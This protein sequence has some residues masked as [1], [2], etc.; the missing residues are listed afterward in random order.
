MDRK[1]TAADATSLDTWQRGYCSNLGDVK[2]FASTPTRGTCV[3]L[4]MQS[5]QCNYVQF[6]SAD[7]DCGLASRCQLPLRAMQHEQYERHY[8]IDARA[9]SPLCTAA[10]ASSVEAVRLAREDA[11]SAGRASGQHA[12]WWESRGWPAPLPPSQAE[13]SVGVWLRDSQPTACA[14]QHKDLG[15]R[16]AGGMVPWHVAPNQ[17]E[18]CDTA[19]F[20]LFTFA[21][22]EARDW[23]HAVRACLRR[24]AVCARCRHISVAPAHGVCTWH[25]ACAAPQR[26][27]LPTG[28]IEPTPCGFR[29]GPVE[30]A[31]RPDGGGGSSENGGEGGG[32][33]GGGG[34]AVVPGGVALV[35]FG[36]HGGE[37]DSVE[38]RPQNMGAAQAQASAPLIERSH[39]RWVANLVNANGGVAFDVFIHSWSPEAAPYLERAWGGML[40][41][42]QHEPTRYADSTSQL[43]GFQCG[44]AAINCARTASQL[45]GVYKALLL[46]REHELAT[47]RVYAAAV[48]ARHDVSLLAPVEL[49]RSLWPTAP[50]TDD[51][52][53]GGGGVATAEVWFPSACAPSASAT[54]TSCAVAAGSSFEV[55]RGCAVSGRLCLGAQ[56]RSL[57]GFRAG[58]GAALVVDWV[59]AAS[60]RAADLMGDAVRHFH[61]Y[62]RTQ[63][64][65]YGD[66]YISTHFIWP[67][68]ALAYGLRPRFGLAH[69]LVLTRHDTD[70]RRW[71][72]EHVREPGRHDWHEKNNA[73][74]LVALKPGE[75]I[76]PHKG[77]W[78]V[79]PKGLQLKGRVNEEKVHPYMRDTCPFESLLIC[80]EDHPHNHRHGRHVCGPGDPRGHERPPIDVETPVPERIE[81]K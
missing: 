29:S 8:T 7:F 15:R 33:S 48:V 51:L 9:Q 59:F 72:V 55:P 81:G 22:E 79:D 53:G 18:T 57:P 67:H 47:G 21:L 43:L 1:Q 12:H 35:F 16:G 40:V 25:Y 42:A 70:E 64:R 20:G 34:G 77:C 65:T 10:E 54:G 50:P 41:C 3:L 68:H 44:V 56:E 4:C 46:K 52:P 23:R 80:P 14:V 75:G 63:A 69:H 37:A 39:R 58:L 11:E 27:E 5:P 28:A 19:D 26:K 31:A 17:P 74:R 76:E 78:H 45:L 32:G 49:P 62:T 2:S 71:P 60:S 66:G 61:N 30:T 13:A 6:A 24:C 36:K 73:S 38:A